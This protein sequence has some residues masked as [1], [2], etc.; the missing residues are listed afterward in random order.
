MSVLSLGRVVVYALAD[1]V[2][3]HVR[4]VGQTINPAYRFSEHLRMPVK[5]G[6]QKN[7]WIKAL[8][9]KGMNPVFVFLDTAEVAEAKNV[10][11]DWITH[12]SSISVL[13]NYKLKNKK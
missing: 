12:F 3:G 8:Q 2:D 13:Y 5:E 10:E 11:A 7:N 4:Y 9:E 6:L 1:P